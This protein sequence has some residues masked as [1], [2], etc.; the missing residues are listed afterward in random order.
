MMWWVV[1]LVEKRESILNGTSR[2]CC[3]DGWDEM[4]GQL[5]ASCQ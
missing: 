1:E 5:R 2:Q 3:T 4:L